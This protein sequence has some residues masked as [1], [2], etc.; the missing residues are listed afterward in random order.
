MKRLGIWLIIFNLLVVAGS[1]QTKRDPRAVGLAG[2]YGTVADGIFAVGYN[3]ALIAIQQDKPFMLQLVG[4]DFGLVNNYIS[5][6]NLNSISGDT[7]TD[8]EKDVILRNLDESGGL[9]LFT[10]V[11]LP[12]PVLNYASGNMALTSN[13]VVLGDI[14]IPT[15]IMSLLLNGNPIAEDLDMTLEM[16]L[17]GVNEFG[18]SFAIPGQ[19]MA[20]GM[21]AKYLQGLFYFG[22]DNDSS[23]SS[24]VTDSTAVH[25][26]GVYFFR[27]GIGGSGIG[28]DIGFT[29]ND[30]NGWRIGVSLINAVGRIHWNRPGFIKNLMAGGDNIY[31]NKDDLFHLNWSGTPLND[32][33]AVRYEY[34]IDTLNVGSLSNDSLF[35]SN[36]TDEQVIYNLDEDGN[37]KKFSTRYPALFRFSVAKRWPDVLVTSDFVTGF[38]DKFF[39][40]NR[41]RWAIGAELLRNPTLPVRFGFSWAGSDFK[42]LG[43][44]FGIHK[45]PVIFDLGLA[46][47]NGIWVH[48][49]KGVNL[50]L[51]VTITSFKSRKSEAPPAEETPVVPIVP[52]GRF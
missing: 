29:T 10:D 35:Y 9:R 45:G 15:G 41:W 31:G 50:S 1:A 7:L 6:A 23:Y 18:F 33:M 13:M 52:E 21:T 3:P 42:E 37:L 48:T 4:F 28:L 19:D 32:S 12:I 38:Q 24:L 27:Q 26:E 20:W 25:G 51:G 17:L 8:H 14:T 44:G 34:Y 5:I 49:M 46:F 40:R 16:D 30:I 36:P 11:H 22:I 47:R 43:M 39:S 2:A